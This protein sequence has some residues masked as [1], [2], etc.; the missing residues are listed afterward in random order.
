VRVGDDVQGLQNASALINISEKSNFNMK[1]YS[2]DI[3]VH[4]SN[5]IMKK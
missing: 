3:R 2:L 4:K 1:L 5:L